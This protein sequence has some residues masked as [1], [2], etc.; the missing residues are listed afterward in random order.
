[1][2]AA[3]A[4]AQAQPAMAEAALELT[5]AVAEAFLEWQQEQ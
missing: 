1:M 2:L 5:P 4:V 3:V